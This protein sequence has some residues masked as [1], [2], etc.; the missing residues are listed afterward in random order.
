[1]KLDD[2]TEGPKAFAEK[3]QP[4]WTTN[5]QALVMS[6]ADIEGFDRVGRSRPGQE[7]QSRRPG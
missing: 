1:L 7:T 2:A 5:R 4:K 6:A 3:R